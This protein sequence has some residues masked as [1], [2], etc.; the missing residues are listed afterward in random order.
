MTKKQLEETPPTREQT[1]AD[2]KEFDEVFIPQDKNLS[3][4]EA[5]ELRIP[6]VNELM[7]KLRCDNF[8][9]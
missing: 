5:F 2:L 3:L 4:E 9:D 7:A 1:E 8:E 6:Q